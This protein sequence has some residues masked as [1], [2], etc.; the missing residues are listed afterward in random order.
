MTTL[1]ISK[2]L[3]IPHSTVKTILRRSLVKLKNKKNLKVLHNEIIDKNYIK[4][5][6][7]EK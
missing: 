7:G 5:L 6:T 1:E 4:T 3:K 2:K